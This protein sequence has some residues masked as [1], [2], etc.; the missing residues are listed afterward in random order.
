MLAF[1]R[2]LSRLLLVIYKGVRGVV[3]CVVEEEEVRTVLLICQVL[4]QLGVGDGG[5]RSSVTLVGLRG[6]QCQA[7]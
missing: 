4:I 7:G 2:T 3:I 5:K 6:R 1:L